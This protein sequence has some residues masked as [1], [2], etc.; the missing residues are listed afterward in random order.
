M[1]PDTAK[2]IEVTLLG[3][4]LEFIILG[5]V[6]FAMVVLER[7]FRPAAES[8]EEEPA[9]AIEASTAVPPLPEGEVVA[10]ISIALAHAEKARGK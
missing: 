5:V 2:G 10:A 6:L 7:V 1:S 8:R 4:T 3:M 9:L